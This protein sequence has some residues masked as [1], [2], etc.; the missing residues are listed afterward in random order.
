[1]R[2]FIIIGV[3]VTL[4]GP[5]FELAGPEVTRFTLETDGLNAQKHEK[6][7]AKSGENGVTDEDGCGTNGEKGSDG[8]NGL[9]GGHAGN[10][11]I[12]ADVLPDNDKIYLSARGGNGS[13]GQIGGNGG[14]G[15]IGANGINGT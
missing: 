8:L 14:R 12:F 9:P 15:G 11:F 7:Q 1:M 4:V 5:S 10:I 3:N 13:N 2:N 6:R